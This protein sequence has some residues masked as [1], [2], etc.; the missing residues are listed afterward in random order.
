MKRNEIIFVCICLGLFILDFMVRY[1]NETE[2]P[3][4]RIIYLK[5]ECESL[6]QENLLLNEYIKQIEED[7]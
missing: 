1:N 5:Q 3:K 2:T 6:K 4:E 7:N